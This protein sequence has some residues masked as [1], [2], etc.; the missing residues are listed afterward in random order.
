MIREK[1]EGAPLCPWNWPA[2]L[3]RRPSRLS[4]FHSQRLPGPLQGQEGVPLPL[5]GW[6]SSPAGCR[7]G[8]SRHLA[9]EPGLPGQPGGTRPWPVDSRPP[10][11]A[12]PAERRPP[13]S[14]GVWSHRGP[15]LWG[16]V[17]VGLEGPLV[18]AQLH[19]AV[20]VCQ[21]VG[22][23]RGEVA[24]EAVGEGAQRLLH[25]HGELPVVVLLQ[26]GT[27]TQDEEAEGRWQVL[28]LKEDGLPVRSLPRNHPSAPRPPLYQGE[29]RRGCPTRVAAARP[30]AGRSLSEEVDLVPIRGNQTS[31]QR[32]PLPRAPCPAQHRGEKVHAG[33]GFPGQPR[34][35]S[36]CEVLIPGWT[37]GP[38][39]G[40]RGSWG[41]AAGLPPP[42]SAHSLTL[43]LMARRRSR[44][45]P[46]L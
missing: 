45:E 4:G 34:P 18:A 46:P 22:E 1:A 21:E 28:S 2:L 5:P 3:C 23:A 24:H 10:V 41:W 16:L 36:R 43:F 38:T 35:P 15:R 44:T 17:V 30:W 32:T 40:R 26:T 9:P 29:A 11:T 37:G 7:A 20:G 33:Q 39:D 42:S 12:G 13:G 19:G 25:V 8:S 14:E 27:Q 6:A 31:Q